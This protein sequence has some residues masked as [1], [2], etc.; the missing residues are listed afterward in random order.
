MVGFAQIIFRSVLVLTWACVALPAAADEVRGLREIAKEVSLRELTS[1]TP[2][3]SFANS[4]TGF[5][6]SQ[7]A[8]VAVSFD[9]PTLDGIDPRTARFIQMSGK[10]TWTLVE[11]EVDLKQR[12]VIA[13]LDGNATA[14]L[15]GA[16][17]FDRVRE[18]QSL[19]CDAPKGSD[20]PRMI[21]SICTRI[22]CPASAM[23]A[24]DSS[25]ENLGHDGLTAMPGAH[26]A[27]NI[28][29]RCL[30]PEDYSGGLL[31]CGITKATPWGDL[32]DGTPEVTL[33]PWWP[34]WPVWDASP[35][36]NLCSPGTHKVGGTSYDFPDTLALPSPFGAT[37][38]RA[39]VRYPA[40][41]YATDAAPSAGQFPLVVFLHGNHCVCA[42]GCGSHSCSAGDRIPNHRGYDY[43]LEVLASRGYVAVSIDGYDVTAQFSGPTMTDYEA[44]G[45]LVLE[46]LRLWRDWT[47]NG[48]GPVGG[49]FF[50]KI[51]LDLI[52]LVGHSR[53]GEGVVAADVLNVAQAEGFN[54]G[55]VLA[56][57]PTDQDPIV[58][59]NPVSPYLVILS[60]NDGDVSNLQ[61]Q[62]TYDRAFTSA[63]PA[64]DR[65]EKTLFWIFGANHNFFNTT[66]T[67]GSGDPF[68]SDDGI[69]SGR[70]NAPAQ[71]RAGC[72]IVT[73]FMEKEL[74]GD[75]RAARAV[76]GEL[77]MT[78]LGGL[79]V[80]IAHQRSKAR[81]VD[82]FDHGNGK[83]VNSLGGAVTTSGV[84]P[85]FEIYPFTPSGG[86]NASFRGATSGLVIG[87]TGAAKYMTNLPQGQGDV[88][89]YRSIS[90]RIARIREGPSAPPLEQPANI[91]LTLID[92]NGV[93]A[94]QRFVVTQAATVPYPAAGGMS[95]TILTT[96]RVPLAHFRRDNKW[97]NFANVAKIRVELQGST[98]LAMDDLMF[99]DKGSSGFLIP[100]FDAVNKV[101]G[102]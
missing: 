25:F 23:N 96:L 49:G 39:E 54:I 36:A 93:E 95:P 88:R 75:D 40:F 4:D 91:G 94:N 71:R 57:A 92:G 28:C 68:A 6:L 83:F 12:R 35:Q 22:L 58:N 34:T 77:P 59:W 21:D 33:L 66:W 32:G 37:D 73:A 90:M 64:A 84:L 9:D 85:L 62:R 16:S 89:R 74:G 42:T 3:P 97:F 81:I 51:D 86:F 38:V 7:D 87:S 56:I 17:R 82:D 29:E 78:G 70:M 31:E 10:N 67:P 61:G 18:Q 72:Q 11:T 60:N 15:V 65:R 80:H 44:R 1:K 27:A 13:R 101:I 45:Q 8:T 52:G 43:I 19:I 5:Y 76:R 48:G 47:Q 41:S 79:E 26:S 14:A 20:I 46:H 30:R 2:I 69:G 50:G 24:I 100:W 98:R 53:G 99:D 63:V 55:A 102:H